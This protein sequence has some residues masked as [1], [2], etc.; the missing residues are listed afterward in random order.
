MVK[1]TV[2]Q[3]SISDFSIEK[4]PVA[5]LVGGG[6]GNSNNLSVS[7]RLENRFI[8]KNLFTQDEQ[9]DRRI[10][11]ET[12]DNPTTSDR[13]PTIS[14]RIL[15]ESCRKPWDRIPT[16][17]CRMSDPTISDG[18]IRQSEDVGRRR[19]RRDPIGIL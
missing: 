19:I 12:P 10:L 6:D 1:L 18:Q 14:D 8:E 9:S 16:G 4:T 17:S 7:L 11:Q 5:T 2:D 13:D 15:S 3:P